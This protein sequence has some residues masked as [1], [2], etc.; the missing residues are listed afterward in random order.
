MAYT[1]VL[2]SNARDLYSVNGRDKARQ[3]AILRMTLG[4]Y[5]SH[6]CRV[7]F[8]AVAAVEILPGFPN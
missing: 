5:C 4:M 7:Q 6:P 3:I 8:A 2:E 1:K